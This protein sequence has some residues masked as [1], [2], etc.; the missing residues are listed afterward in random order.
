MGVTPL[1][2]PL[3]RRFAPGEVNGVVTGAP[4]SDG[5]DLIGNVPG[6]CLVSGSP[7][8]D[9]WLIDSSDGAV[10]SDGGCRASEVSL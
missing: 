10:S 4:V 2:N 7:G 3:L 5:N 1:C 9:F 8:S 6:D